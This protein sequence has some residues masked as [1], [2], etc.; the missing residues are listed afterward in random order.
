MMIDFDHEA[1]VIDD[2]VNHI[3]GRVLGLFE[4]EHDLLKWWGGPSVTGAPV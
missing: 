3:V 2:L 4:I 1:K